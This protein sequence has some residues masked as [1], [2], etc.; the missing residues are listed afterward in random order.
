MLKLKEKQKALDERLKLKKIEEIKENIEKQNKKSETNLLQLQENLDSTKT[1]KCLLTSMCNLNEVKEREEQNNLFQLEIDPMNSFYDDEMKRFVLKAKPEYCIKAFQRSAADVKVDNP[2]NIRTPETLSFTL[3]YIIN[4]LIDLDIYDTGKYFKTKKN[5]AY[6]FQDICSFV[7]DRLRSIRQDF[8]I[9]N[10]KGNFHCINCHEKIAR[11]LI[12][13]LN[14]CLDY[15]SFTG[16]QSSFKLIYEQLNA[17]LTLLREF[18]HYVDTCNGEN[19]YIS[20]NQ[21]EFYAYSILLSFNDKCDM[22]S[23]LNK[24]PDNVKHDEII[25]TSKKISKSFFSQDFINFFKLL[26]NNKFYLSACLMSLYFKD[27]RIELIEI[28]TN[29]NQ[30]DTGR[31]TIS[32]EKLTD[33]LCFQDIT[34]SFQFLDWY[35]IDLNMNIL[36]YPEK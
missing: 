13:C 8:I 14:Q 12:L 29:K 4:E 3:N 28:L 23:L 25:S 30:R 22:L 31:V 19:V 16:H 11:F 20:P 9:I 10:E 26:R 6:N 15:E 5:E 32:L 17:T 36:D 21:S 24:L 7:L 33:I 34:E 1:N 2:E 18:Y 27:M 35:G